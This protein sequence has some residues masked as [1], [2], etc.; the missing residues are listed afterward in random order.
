ML[1]CYRVPTATPNPFS[2][3]NRHTYKHAASSPERVASPATY[4][5]MSRAVIAPDDCLAV[6]EAEAAAEVALAALEADRVAEVTVAFAGLI[7][8]EL[9]V[10]TEALLFASFEEVY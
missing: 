6:D 1:E 7:E 8:E 10:A 9:A 2:S 5:L 4:L 3:F